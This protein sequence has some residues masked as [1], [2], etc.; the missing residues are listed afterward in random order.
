LEV[1]LEKG[2][3]CVPEIRSKTSRAF[4]RGGR[5]ERKEALHK[6]RV[7]ISDGKKGTEWVIY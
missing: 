2:L 5:E 6:V 1:R 7:T 4:L 3:A